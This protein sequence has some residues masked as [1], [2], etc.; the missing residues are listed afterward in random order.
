MSS[1]LRLLLDGPAH[2]AFNMGV[3][4]ALLAS[5]AGGLATLRLYTWEGHWLSLGYGQPA[6]PARSAA[7]RV[8]GVGLVRRATGGAAVLHGSDLTYALAAPEDALPPG[9]AG[10]YGLV[11]EAL[12]EALAAVGVKAQR[13][14][15]G[16]G[17][18]RGAPRAFDCFVA[19]AADEI[20]AGP[21]AGRKLVGSAQRRAG[22]GVL[23]HGSI[24]LAPEPAAA[25]RA[26]GLAPEYAT[27]VSEDVGQAAFERA[28][29][30]RAL[31]E[32]LAAA[33]ARRLGRV[34]G[35]GVL[36]PDEVERARARVRSHA[37]DPLAGPEPPGD[38]QL[39]R[40]PKAGR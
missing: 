18:G 10:V 33:L 13:S 34:C 2:G 16:P 32:A 21:G 14:P 30:S 3:D 31:G 4:E 26:A 11:A 39:S 40:G 1:A 7:C 22:G 36:H 15:R 24:R 29:G 28:G 35:A 37:R 38:P 19:P 27:S 23:Q 20:C 25:A 9:L 5:A 8:A 6:D 12:L 17:A